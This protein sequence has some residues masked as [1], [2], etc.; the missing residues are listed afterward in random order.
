MGAGP[1]AGLRDSMAQ[2]RGA[3]RKHNG[4][5]MDPPWTTG[6]LVPVP[7]FSL[8]LSERHGVLPQTADL[9]ARVQVLDLSF[10]LCGP[11]QLM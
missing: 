8:A 7:T 10:L 1:R 4:V 11:E 9:T 2:R 3:E 5:E 6:Q